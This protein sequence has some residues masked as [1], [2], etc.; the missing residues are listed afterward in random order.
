MRAGQPTNVPPPDHPELS[1][2]MPVYNGEA[3]IGAVLK[4]W[5]AELDRLKI[6]YE[7]LVYD[8]G[9]VDGTPAVLAAMAKDDSRLVVRRHPNVGHGPTILKGYEQ[10]AGEWVFQTDSDNETT[11]AGF[12]QLWRARDGSDLLLGC[13]E[14]RHGTFARRVITA[15]AKTIVRV[16]FGAGLWDVNTPYRLMRRSALTTMTACIPP[17]AFA[18][19]VLIAGLAVR[20]QLRI[21]Q[22]WVAYQP[23][24]AGKSSLGGL[25]Q[26][27]AA[28]QAAFQT[29]S[30]ALK[31]RGKPRPV[32]ASTHDAD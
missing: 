1:I 30:V 11:P 27:R 17:L 29:V 13:R 16:L 7:F 4:S 15:T 23:R 22:T 3:T 2:V 28:V 18:P 6:R 31:S 9:S 20:E 5:V 32:G 26:W 14:D 10:A 12:E 25:R 19:N 21:W 24:H 8:D